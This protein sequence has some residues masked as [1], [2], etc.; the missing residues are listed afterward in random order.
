MGIDFSSG[1]QGFV[2]VSHLCSL[3]NLIITVETNAW[4]IL[5]SGV[6]FTVVLWN[7]NFLVAVCTPK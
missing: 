1:S 3:M 6:P 2:R 7:T 4:E 5:I